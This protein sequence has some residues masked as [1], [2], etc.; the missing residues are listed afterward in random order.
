[1]S[2]AISRKDRRIQ[3]SRREKGITST[4]NPWDWKGTKGIEFKE[5]IK[6]NRASEIYRGV[7]AK[8]G[9]EAEK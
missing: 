6:G 1:M 7:I 8:S 5:K 3:S 2:L 4:K 9:Q